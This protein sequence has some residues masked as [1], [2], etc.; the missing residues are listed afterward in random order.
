MHQELD[1]DVLAHIRDKVHHLVNP[2]LAVA[3]LMENRLKDIAV[4]IGDVSVLPV[5]V[6]TP[7]VQSQ[8]QKFSV[9]S[10]G[11]GRKS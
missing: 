3:T 9:A 10:A 11:T 8:C 1:A 2:R 7:V 6:M 4:G 5:E